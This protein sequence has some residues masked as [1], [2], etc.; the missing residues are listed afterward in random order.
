MILIGGKSKNPDIKTSPIDTFH[1]TNL[2]WIDPVKKPGFLVKESTA[3]RPHELY[4][5]LS[6]FAFLKKIHFLPVCKHAASP[7]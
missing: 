3:V 2:T 4:G 5:T 7:P 6:G 1:V